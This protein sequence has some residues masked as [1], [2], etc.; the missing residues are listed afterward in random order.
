MLTISQIT[1][2]LIVKEPFTVDLLAQGVVNHSALA[3]RLRPKIEAILYKQVQLGA[4]I[5]ALKR[6][7]KTLRSGIVDKL[8]F[9]NPDMLVRSNL[10][11]LT[12]TTKSLNRVEQLSRLHAIANEKNLFFA[13]TQGVVETTIITSCDLKERLLKVI[14]TNAIVSQYQELSAITIKLNKETVTTPGAYYF[15]LKILA[16]RDINIIE[17]VSTYTEVTIIFADRDV[18]RAFSVL[19]RGLRT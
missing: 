2:E 13:I 7:K 14:E 10:M 1:E 6:F 19:K 16:W 3:R 4:I 8:P 17:I 9:T 15:I 11:E 18:E 12:L 5:M